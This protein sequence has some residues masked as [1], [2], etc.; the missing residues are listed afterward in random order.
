MKKVISF[1]LVLALVLGSFSMAFALTDVEGNDAET[2][3]KVVN[4]LGI[5][6]GYTDGSFQ[7]EKAVTRAEFAAMITRALDI[8]ESALAGYTTTTFKDTTGYGWAVKYLAFCNDKG[9]MLGDGNGNVMPGRTINMNEAMTMVL[10]AMGLTDNAATLVGNW[11]A[12]YVTVAKAEGLYD[13]VPAVTTVDRATA[14]Q[15]IYNALTVDGYEVDADGV[16]YTGSKFI[17]NL[18]DSKAVDTVVVYDADSLIPM[19]EYIGALATVYY[20]A[21]QEVVAVDPSSTFVTGTFSGT[22]T[23][24]I[25]EVD[26]TIAAGAYP[27]DVQVVSNGAV[28][29]TM[30][31]LTAGDYTIA[32]DIV[33]KTIKTV[34]SV[35]DWDVTVD[36][37]ADED[38]QDEIAD[39]QTLLDKEFVL[40]VNGDIKA[41]SYEILGVAALADIAEDD[42]VYVYTHPVTD[43][44]VKIEVGTE[45]VTGKVTKVFYDTDDATTY[46]AIGGNNYAV[47]NGVTLSVGDEGTATLDYAGDIYA[48]EED[49]SL[50]GNY[51]VLVATDSAVS[52]GEATDKVKLFTKDGEV[53]TPVLSDDVTLASASALVGTIVDYALNS[54]GEVSELEGAVTDATLN[55]DVEADGTIIANKKVAKNVIVFINDSGDYSLGKVT[56]LADTVTIAAVVDDNEIVAFIEDDADLGSTDAS[57]GIIT[58]YG[59]DGLDADGDPVKLADIILETV[60]KEDVIATADLTAYVATTG[61]ALYEIT[62]DED[63]A[64]T[65]ATT[66]GISSV[67]GPVT[68]SAIDGNLVTVAGGNTYQVGDEVVVY[69]YDEDDGWAVGKLS[70][71][72]KLTIEILDTDADTD[73]AEYVIAW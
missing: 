61:T 2:A 22:A 23:F 15:I 55:G 21:D 10:R 64:I 6:T 54:D 8:P 25:D 3:I 45:T 1:V 63:G 30:A 73:G 20:N 43:K 24:T 66:A 35:V 46:Y 69:I 47:T 65:A 56:D 50:V 33:G 5:V 53:I 39:D 58:A 12:N 60:V 40:D 57:Y 67:V 18:T 37:Q 16:V 31:A 29:G 36:D 52:F 62:V 4:D 70:A 72:K 71:V 42:V 49:S 41:G 68:V 44:I 27:E 38:I 51:A 26:Y 13:N 32:A 34:Y 17:D 59:A 48:W 7:P 9:I 28:V 14:A 19:A 11:P